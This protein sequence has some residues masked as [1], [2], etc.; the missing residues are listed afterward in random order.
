MMEPSWKELP[1]LID[2]YQILPETISK[3]CGTKLSV[4][5]RWSQGYWC[6]DN[7]APLA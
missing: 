1:G 3:C 7:F 4:E 5:P 2:G 6:L